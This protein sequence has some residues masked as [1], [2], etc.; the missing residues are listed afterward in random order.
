M[1]LHIIIPCKGRERVVQVTAAHLLDHFAIARTYRIDLTMNWV[2]SEDALG[3]KLNKAVLS[4]QGL[5]FDY[6]MILGSDD[7]MRPQIW[8]YIR[9]AIEEGL[10]AFGFNQAV[11]YDRIEHRA[12]L[13]R[14]GPVTFG[15]GRCIRRDVIEACDWRMWDDE[16]E[17]GIDNNQEAILMGNANTY[18]HI[19]PTHAPVICDIK[20][21]DNLNSFDSVP[22]GELNPD[23]IIEIFS[24]LKQFHHAVHT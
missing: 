14:Y 2:T 1:K 22:G 6:L 7:L 24:D 3:E 17:N 18:I 21:G 12:K 19:I 11:L 15:A 10:S 9:T 20:D 5:N 8:G 4:A 16:K 13:W 23:R